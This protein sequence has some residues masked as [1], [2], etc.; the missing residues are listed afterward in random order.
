MLA[1]APSSALTQHP[2]QT[3][4]SNGFSPLATSSAWSV[5]IL[6]YFNPC[7]AHPS[8]LLGEAPKDTKHANL[9]PILAKVPRAKYLLATHCIQVALGEIEK[10]TVYSN[11]HDNE[12]EKHIGN[13]AKQPGNEI[14]LS[15]MQARTSE[16]TLQR[17]GTTYTSAILP[18]ATWPLFR[19][20]TASKY[21]SSDIRS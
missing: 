7:G 16:L 17:Y 2:Q 13:N 11:R 15:R 19:S 20:L 14:D 8:G 10:L 4:C 9:M 5:I 21:V 1:V 12:K 18:K 6:R 3:Y